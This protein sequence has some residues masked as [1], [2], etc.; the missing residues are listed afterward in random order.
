MPAALLGCLGLWQSK[1]YI[2]HRLPPVLRPGQLSHLLPF[3]ITTFRCAYNA[4]SHLILRRY[5][6]RR[7]CAMHCDGVGRPAPWHDSIRSNN[8]DLDGYSKVRG[9]TLSHS[10]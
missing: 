6:S 7:Y 2:E 3:V 1:I 10:S 5:D 9:Q 4:D 8:G